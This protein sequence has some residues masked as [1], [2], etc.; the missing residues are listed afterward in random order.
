MMVIITVDE[1]RAYGKREDC[2]RA[3]EGGLLS[4]VFFNTSQRKEKSDYEMPSGFLILQML[5]RKQSFYLP[6]EPH[7][8]VPCKT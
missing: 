8:Y 3:R 1:L 4:A 2:E 6:P 7:V 5:P